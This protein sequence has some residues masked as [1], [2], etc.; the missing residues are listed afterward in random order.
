MD[1]KQARH[2]AL[3]DLEARIQSA[4]GGRDEDSAGDQASGPRNMS[5]LGVAA[6]ISVEMVVTTL[7]G[8][9]LGWFV[10]GWLGTRPWLMIIFMFLGGAAGI[11]NV[12]R[13]VRGL[14][15]GVGLGRAMRHKDTSADGSGHNQDRHHER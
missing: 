5:G 9:A 1:E 3:S 8:T 10:D 2:R 12:Y 13:V 6:R 4:S 7:V 15:D 14:D 11:S